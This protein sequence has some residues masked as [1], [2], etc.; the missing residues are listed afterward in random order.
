VRKSKLLIITVSAILLVWASS[1]AVLAQEESSEAPPPYKALKNPF[2]WDNTSAQELGKKIY[3]KSCLGCHGAKGDSLPKF[4]FS[5]VDYPQRLEEEPDYYYWILSEGRTN[6][7]MPPYKSSLSE[8]QRWQ[9]LTYIW[10][11]GKASP[12]PEA[13]P[14]TAKPAVEG[15]SLVLSLPRQANSGQ[16]LTLV[17]ALQSKEGKPVENVTVKFLI[18]MNF[19]ATGLME[20]GEAITNN[21]G[22]AALAYIPREEG[23]I[24]VFAR[25]ETIEASTKILLAPTNEPFYKTEVGIRLPALGPEV[26]LGPKLAYELGE[27][28]EAPTSALKLP[29]GISSWLLI[30]V[31]AVMLVWA[32]Y[33]VVMY[34]V[35]RIPVA[36]EVGE[37]NIR[38]VPLAGLLIIIALGILLVLMII[39]GPYTHF[40]LF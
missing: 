13:K 30:V 3:Q 39:T 23:E 9:V 34:Q 7:G 37:T 24:E 8:E 4:D 40:H 29:S 19:F 36:Q 1:V 12:P 26:F 31:L 5:A 35:F 22:V 10:S 27:M 2:P 11:L 21:K 32:T 18:K 15:I 17:A 28:G 6:G 20:I 38:L 25:Y 14:P 16:P 33:F